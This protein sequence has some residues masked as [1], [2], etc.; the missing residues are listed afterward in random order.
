MTL[1]EIRSVLSE[2]SS[3]PIVKKVALELLARVEALE[4]EVA[5]L[6]ARPS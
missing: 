3:G 5:A 1:D 6:R 4:K 2:Y